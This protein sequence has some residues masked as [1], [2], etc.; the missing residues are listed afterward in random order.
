MLAWQFRVRCLVV[1]AFNVSLLLLGLSGLGL[2]GLGVDVVRHAVDPDKVAVPKAPF[3]LIDPRDYEPMVM[4]A[5]VAGA[6]M[7]LAL[8]RAFLGYGSAISAADLSMRRIAVKLR[9]DVYDKLQR[10]SF[11]FYDANSSG[12]IINRVT[13]D[14]NAMTQFVSGVLIAILELVL[15]LTVYLTYML[16]IHVGLTLAGLA[17]TPILWWLTVRF[18]RTVRPEYVKN[19]ELRDQMINTLSESVQGVHVVKGFAMQRREVER[20]KAANDSVSSQQSLIFRKTSTFNPMVG[21][22]TNVN[23]FVL[24]IFGG[25]LVMLHEQDASKGIA[26]GTGLVVFAGLLQQ[27]SNQVGTVANI[28]NTIQVSLTAAQRVFEVLDAPIEVQSPP[29]PRKL[30][31]ARGEI[32]FDHVTFGYDPKNPVL[33]DISLK[34]EPGQCVA[35]VGATGAGKSTLLSLIPRFYDPDKGRVIVDGHDL[36]ALDLDEL[37]RNIGLVFQESFLFSNTVAFNIAFGHPNASR[38]QVEKAARIAAAHEFIEKL[39]K[40]Y[41]TLLSENAVNLSG[42][43]RQRLAIARAVLLEPKI[44]L[45]DD[46]TAAVDPE[47]EHEILDAMDAAM[48]GRTTFVVAHRLSTLRRADK[49]IVLNAG[50]V[51][52]VGTHDQLMNHAGGHYQQAANLQTADDE[53]LRLLGMEEP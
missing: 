1:L 18:S 16:N 26:L 46:P 27:F 53:S 6:I 45:L 34:V 51:V 39:P 2:V 32:V 31:N 9:S 29:N 22:L 48:Q 38:E 37:R 35:I 14:T 20:F 44:L 13:G 49:V 19:R 43:Q 23:L 40:G 10:L 47:T 8:L 50:R 4:I 12:S 5:I 41:D 21:F 11:R 42:G 30:G 3:G 28:S 7:A 24:L 15:S 36:R 17:T 52:E 25:Y 33:H